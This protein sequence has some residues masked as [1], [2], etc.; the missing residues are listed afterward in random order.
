MSSMSGSQQ[1]PIDLSSTMDVLPLQRFALDQFSI[2]IFKDKVYQI[3]ATEGPRIIIPVKF[4]AE[5]KGLPEETLSAYEAVNEALLSQYTHFSAGAHNETLSKL[6][7]TN[8]SQRLSRLTPKLKQELEFIAAQEFPKCDEWTPFKAQPFLVRTVARLSGCSFAG[9]TLSR[10]EEW[11]DTSV[12]YATTVFIAAIK[13]QFFPKWMRPVAQYFIPDFYAIPRM[14]AKAQ[15]RLT[16]IIE[17]RL[18]DS[19]VPGYQRP[20]DFIQWLLDALPEEQ[21]RSFGLQAHLQ[22]ILAAASIHTTSN[23]VTD[24]VYDLAMHQDMQEVLRQ[25]AAEVLEGGGGGG[26]YGKDSLARLKKMDSFMRESQRLHGNVTSFI[27]KVMKPI[28]LSDGTHLPAG[29]S[30]LA[31]LAGVSRDDRFYPGAETFDGLRFW[32]LQQQQQQQQNSANGGEVKNANTDA[33]VGNR[34]QFTS[35]GDANMNFGLGRHACPGRFFAA[36][37]TKLIL[38]YLVLHYDVRLRE[39]EG[40]PAPAMF[41]MTKSPSPDAEIL[42]RRRP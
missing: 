31:P 30:L 7:R 35:I 14:V 5:L 29:T 37:E 11:M 42:F 18:R 38:A 20:D 21:K 13:L 22:L 1:L 9:S 10:N 16:P 41:M 34:W 40:R 3:E 33:N 36:A 4:I 24:C 2:Y 15:A 26:W 19:E 23:L 6:L 39:G 28:D 8:L 32:K 12:N 25:E 27:R 17:E